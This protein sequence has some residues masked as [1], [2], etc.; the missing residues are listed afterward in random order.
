MITKRLVKIVKIAKMAICNA[1]K[2]IDQ[3]PVFEPKESVLGKHVELAAE[4]HMRR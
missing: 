1:Q 2:M 3:D 4:A